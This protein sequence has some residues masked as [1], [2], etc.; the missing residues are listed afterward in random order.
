VRT[1]SQEEGTEFISF[2]YGQPTPGPG[3]GL[4]VPTLVGN[5]DVESEALWAYELG[6]RIQPSQRVSVDLAAFYNDYDHL[7]ERLPSDFIPGTPG[8]M[9]LRPMNTLRGESYGGEAVVSMAATDA[10]R[11]SASYSFLMMHMHGTDSANAESL[12]LNAPTHQFVL[13]S[14]YDFTRHVS[15]DAQLRYVDNVQ[16][17]PAYLTAD[18]RL[19]WRPTDDLELSLVGQ[20]LFDDQHPEQASTIGLP[21]VEVPRGF[22]GKLTW[23]F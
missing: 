11:W 1:P 21:T 4:F 6:Y 22:Y 10:W 2:I 12:E 17:V 13:R 19:S 14:A 15:L 8:V 16:S 18:I 5:E 9:I 7:M 20:N 3:G 23:R